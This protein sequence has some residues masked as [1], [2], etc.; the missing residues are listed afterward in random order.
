M[1]PV[2]F[3][4]TNVVM[5]APQGAENVNDV[6]AFRNRQCCV[7]AWKFTAEEIDE[8]NRTGTLFLSVFMGGGMPPVFLGCESEVRA[9]AADYGETFP[10][11]DGQA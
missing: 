7:T 10:K 8:I 1:I 4:G 6:P 2:D 5:K 3:K 11:Q 9:L